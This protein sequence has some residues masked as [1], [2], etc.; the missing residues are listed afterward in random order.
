MDVQE[1]AAKSLGYNRVKAE[2]EGVISH[3]MKGTDVFVALPTRY[4]KSICY[5]TVPYAFDCPRL[6]ERSS[7]VIVISPLLV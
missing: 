1:R 5:A 6:V 7:I 2:Q 3:F 4:G